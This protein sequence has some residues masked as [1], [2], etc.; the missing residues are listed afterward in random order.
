[1]SGRSR[2]TDPREGG[3]LAVVCTW[4]GRDFT[5]TGLS[6]EEADAALAEVRAF[7]PSA[8]VTDLLPGLAARF[9]L[10]ARVHLGSRVW[11]RNG[12]GT[13]AEGEP[14]SYARWPREGRSPWFFSATAAEVCVLLD[15]EDR[16][17]WWRATW[18]DS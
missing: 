5:A 16:P 11:W 6:R 15:G 18:L 4:R 14:E 2:A 8:H 3:T 12:S 17:S 13:V 9:P 10:G 1:M 7:D